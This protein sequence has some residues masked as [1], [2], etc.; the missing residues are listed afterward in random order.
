MF[1]GY[2]PAGYPNQKSFLEIIKD[3]EK[4][5]VGIFEFGYPPSDAYADGKVIKEA[6]KHVDYSIVRS[7]DYWRR[8][9]N[10]ISTPI[11][12]M[13]YKKD[14][15]DTG[16]YLE[17]AKSGVVDAF[18]IPDINLKTYEVLAQ[19]LQAYN[20]D[21]V[22]F[23]TN[24]SSELDICFSK[25]SLVY[26]QLVKGLTGTN[27]STDIDFSPVFHEAKKHSDLYL[28]GGFGVSTGK[29]AEFVINSGFKGVII[30]TALIKKL[31]ESPSMLLSFIK[32]IN[33]SIKGGA[34]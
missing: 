17:L 30:G 24:D 20:V 19:E 4:Y 9:R 29:Q 32:E 3:C 1:V 28:F 21:I 23:V 18:V 5:G 7:I 22:C 26:Y 16:T 27:C 34:D 14:I 33:Q 15:V 31:N 8:I 10:T 12:I 25:S 6:Y 13:G 2:L 11:W